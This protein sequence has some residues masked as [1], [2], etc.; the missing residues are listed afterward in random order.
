[1]DRRENTREPFFSKQTVGRIILFSLFIFLTAA[2]QASFFG[3]AGFFPATPD[4]LLA[5]VMGLAMF[6]GERTG[7]VCG[8]FAGVMAD[9]LGGSGT[10]FMPLFYMLAGYVTGIAIRT[11]LTRNLLSWLVYMLAGILFRGSVTFMYLTVFKRVYDVPL[12]LFRAVLPEA[13][14]T[15]VFSVPLYFVSKLCAKPF[16]RESE[17]E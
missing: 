15:F 12:L 2:F 10:L 14:M 1:M 3:A 9:A 4:L 6:D 13:L 5:A 11:F 16:L 7:A 8:L 17:L